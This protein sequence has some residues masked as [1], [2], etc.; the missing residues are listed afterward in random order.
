MV[1]VPLADRQE[2]LSYLH[3]GKSARITAGLRMPE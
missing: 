1:A 3:A 2:C